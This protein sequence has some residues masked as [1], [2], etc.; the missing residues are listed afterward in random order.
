MAL[1]RRVPLPSRSSA[2]EIGAGETETKRDASVEL[3]QVLLPPV[4][5]AG[6]A[7]SVRPFKYAR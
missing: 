6:L 3:V 2:D 5:A 1:V 7:A 4:Y